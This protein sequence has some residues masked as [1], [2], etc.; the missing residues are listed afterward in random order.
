MQSV[1]SVLI[2]SMSSEERTFRWF[3]RGFVALKLRE[4]GLN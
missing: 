2:S 4:E 3:V 1:S